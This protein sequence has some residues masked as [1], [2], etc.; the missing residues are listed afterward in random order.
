M[1]VKFN[2]FVYLCNRE[3]KERV[4]FES[5]NR[6]LLSHCDKAIAVVPMSGVFLH[7]SLCVFVL[8]IKG[9]LFVES[10]SK[11]FDRFIFSLKFCTMSRTIQKSVLSK[12]QDEGVGARVRR[13]VG[14][15]E[16]YYSTV[17][18]APFC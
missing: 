12:W 3:G 10:S 16:V 8:I 2:I 1:T 14:R 13:S 5:R 11:Q 4:L 15:P 17:L 7:R 18:S 9:V 6:N